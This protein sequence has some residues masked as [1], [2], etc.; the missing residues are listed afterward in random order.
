MSL[1]L[2]D[3]RSHLPGMTERRVVQ[4][5]TVTFIKTQECEHM[6]AAIKAAK[7]LPKNPTMRYV[8]SVPLLVGQQWA[9][10]C[11][12]AIGTKGWRDYAHKKLRT[13]DYSKLRGE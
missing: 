3:T 4:D 1:I 5:G 7:E 10:E 12:F 6:F 13:R 8:G 9:K 2:P 11:G